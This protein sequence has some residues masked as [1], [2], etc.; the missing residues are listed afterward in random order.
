MGFFFFNNSGSISAYN[1]SSGVWEVGGPSGNSATFRSVQDTS[2]SGF[3][4]PEN[5]L[6]AASDGDRIAY[7]SYDYSSNALIKYNGTDST[8]VNIGPR[9]SGEQWIMGV[10]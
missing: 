1:D 10:Y 7:L 4:S 9:P 6:L 8:F 2:V 5:T 3:D